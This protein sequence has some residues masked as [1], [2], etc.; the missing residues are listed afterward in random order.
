MSTEIS[1]ERKTLYTIGLITTGVGFVSFL[2]VFAFA[3]FGDP[4]RMGFSFMAPGFIG[5]ILIIVGQGIATFARLGK[6]GSGLVLDPK[7]A[8]EDLKP[9]SSQVGGMLNDVLDE[10]DL[11]NK[12]KEVVKVR[13]R[14]CQALNDEDAR[15]CKHCGSIL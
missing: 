13:C 11:P 2:S 5:F 8:R 7:Q 15:F 12:T 1:K 10:V 6:A 3:F 4:F 9:Y 14:H